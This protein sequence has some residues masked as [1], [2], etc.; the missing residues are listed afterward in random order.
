VIRVIRARPVGS[1]N[2]TGVICETCP[3]VPRSG[4]VSGISATLQQAGL[5]IKLS[6]LNSHSKHDLLS[7]VFSCMLESN[8]GCD[9]G[10][11]PLIFKDLRFRQE[12]CTARP[13]RRIESS[14]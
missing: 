14:I 4:P 8:R 13:L 12:I 3:L 11:K 2:R 5:W 10:Y 9:F 1:E 6:D 7:G